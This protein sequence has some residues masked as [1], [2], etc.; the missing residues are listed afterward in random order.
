MIR[1]LEQRLPFRAACCL[2]D[3]DAR[4]MLGRDKEKHY[5]EASANLLL[6]V[7]WGVPLGGRFYVNDT[8]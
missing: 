5:R 8:F 6:R 4:F 2:V 1:Q 7:S 3:N